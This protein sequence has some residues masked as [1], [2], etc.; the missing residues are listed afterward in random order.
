VNPLAG[1]RA[2]LAALA[3]DARVLPAGGGAQEYLQR[4][5]SLKANARPQSSSPRLARQRLSGTTMVASTSRSGT[6]GSFS[7]STRAA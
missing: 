1:I 5:L 2:P 4:G 6:F 7:S 3:E